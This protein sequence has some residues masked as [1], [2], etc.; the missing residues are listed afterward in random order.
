MGQAR[1]GSIACMLLLSVGDV[2]VEGPALHAKNEHN[3]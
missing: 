3:S 1:A 2:H